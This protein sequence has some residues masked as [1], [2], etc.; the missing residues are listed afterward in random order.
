M[1]TH[2]GVVVVPGTER[3][4]YSWRELVAHKIA[5]K[6]MREE[7]EARARAAQEAEDENE[8]DETLLDS[9]S[10]D[11]TVGPET[12]LDAFKSTDSVF[13]DSDVGIT[14]L[15]LPLSSNNGKQS[16]NNSGDVF[17]GDNLTA[18]VE[19]GEKQVR[20]SMLLSIS[21]FEG[22]LQKTLKST[23]KENHGVSTTAFIGM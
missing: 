4:P 17:G 6:K 12:P 1:Q 9:D 19:A 21:S 11:D 20:I 10:A 22:G 13:K 8:V 3:V 7:Q 23:S 18:I 16:I 15:C 14:P 5:K 2:V